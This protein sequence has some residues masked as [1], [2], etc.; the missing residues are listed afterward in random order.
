SVVD[1][2][3]KNA[4]TGAAFALN[5]N[6][7]AIG[8]SGLAGHFQ[9]PAHGRIDGDYAAK[10][11]APFRALDGV[12]QTHTKRE[13]FAG[14]VKGGDHIGQVEWLDE[15][16]EGAQLHGFHRAVDHVV[17]AHH[18]DNRAGVRLL[19]APENFNTVDTGEN[20]IDE[21]EIRLFVSEDLESFL[22]RGRSEDLK[23]FFAQTARDGAEREL[24]VVD[25]QD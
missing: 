3:G 23:T 4:F 18:Q 20:D 19:H 1:G 11:V 7:G 13:H 2:P 10:I 8:L 9:H 15:V 21:G 22:A 12:P 25:H 16:V 17:R 6:G 5:E 24:F 14:A